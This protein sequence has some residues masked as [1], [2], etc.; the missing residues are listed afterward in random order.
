MEQKLRKYI[1]RKFY[2]YPKTNEI[3]ELREELYS[4]M[5][6]K[7]NDGLKRGFSAEQSY[8]E[9]IT[10]LTNYKTAIAEVET[11]SSLGALKK[12]LVSSLAFSAFYFAALTCIYLYVSI[13]LLRSF[14]QTWLIMVGGAFIY[15]LYFSASML[16]YA[17]LFDMRILARWTVGLLFLSLIPLIYVF[18]N[19]VLSEL[20]SVHKWNPSWILILVLIFVYLL[21][22]L[23]IFA[24]NMPKLFQDIQLLIAGSMLTT[25]AYLIV[26]VRYDLWSRAWIMY[27]LYLAIVSLA[28]YIGEKHRMTKPAVIGPGE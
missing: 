15:L 22:D 10:I 11:G 9:A 17:K 18:P 19:L 21:V 27:V 2:M 23:I 3:V 1:D 6:D 20:Y 13:I 8:Q 5:L 28:F 24:K 14:E 4:M 7:Y 12:R 26:S 25:I 16:G